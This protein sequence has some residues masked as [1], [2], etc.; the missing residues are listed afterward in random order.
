MSIKGVPSSVNNS[1][2]VHALAAKTIAQSIQSKLYDLA[3][4]T[5]DTSSYGLHSN[6]PPAAWDQMVELLR[7][8]IAK[9][10]TTVQQLDRDVDWSLGQGYYE[11]E[12]Q[13]EY[14]QKI[15]DH[16]K[17]AERERIA[18]EHEIA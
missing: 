8:E 6:V 10:E 7:D 4:I 17:E 1:N 12:F 13:R 5:T 11:E 15:K 9:L 2:A 3:Q 16:N 14:E 18:Q